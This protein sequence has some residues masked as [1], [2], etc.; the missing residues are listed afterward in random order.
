LSLKINK[1]GEV[2]RERSGVKYGINP[3]LEA[4]GA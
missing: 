2:K 1:S 3:L 4:G